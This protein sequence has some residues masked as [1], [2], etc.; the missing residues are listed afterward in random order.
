MEQV[1]GRVGITAGPVTIKLLLEAG[2]H[3]GHQT[4]RWNPKMRSY[5]FTQRND[6]HIIDLQQTVV[7]LERACAFG[8]A[9][10]KAT[11]LDDLGT[12]DINT[13]DPA[14][15][16][17]LE[18]WRKFKKDYNMSF[19]PHEIEH[20]LIS[21]RYGFNGTPDRW[22]TPKSTLI[23]I[24]TSTSMTPATAIKTMSYKMLVEENFPIKIKKRIGVQLTEKGYKITPYNDSSDKAVFLACLHIFNWKKRRGT[25]K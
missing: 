25:L 4:S 14:I 7:M 20:R 8:N 1:E 15:A 6:I 9:V 3:F 17:Y 2:A 23:D 5:I 22:S 10:H 12:L 16:P 13:V 24:K 11:E 18:G 21:K 19:Q